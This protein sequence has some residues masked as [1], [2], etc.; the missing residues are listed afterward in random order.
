MRLALASPSQSTLP[1]TKGAVRSARAP[2]RPGSDLW[3][4][5][6]PP[7]LGLGTLGTPLGSPPSC[8]SHRPIMLREK[9]SFLL[10]AWPS[11][12]F[13]NQADGLSFSP[14]EPL[15]WPGSTLPLPAELMH[16][17]L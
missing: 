6:H 11:H 15:F 14:Y 8:F 12:N 17:P 13:W 3:H 1:G 10:F 16:K 2:P 7:G 9:L 4:P 5:P